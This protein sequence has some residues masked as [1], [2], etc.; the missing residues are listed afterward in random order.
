ME[1]RYIKLELEDHI[2]KRVVPRLSLFVKYCKYLSNNLVLSARKNTIYLMTST[3]Q[4][5]AR[6]NSQPRYEHLL[7]SF[8]LP[9]QGTAFHSRFSLEY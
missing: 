3:R 6:S 8:S 5:L 4:T 2:G 9:F 7:L 1:V